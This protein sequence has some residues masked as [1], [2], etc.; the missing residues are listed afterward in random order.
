MGDWSG[1]TSW[2]TVCRRASGR[3]YWHSVMRCRREV[4]RHKVAALVSRYGGFDQRG[5]A[6]AIARELGVHRSTISRDI[7]SLFAS[8][9]TSCPHCNGTLLDGKPVCLEV[10]A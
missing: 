2:D 1:R 8:Q 6:S 3:R 10:H 5:V 4:R 9:Y 7:A